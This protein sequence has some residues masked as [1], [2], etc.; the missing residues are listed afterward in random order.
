[1]ERMQALDAAQEKASGGLDPVSST[2]DGTPGFSSNAAKMVMKIFWCARYARMDLL[3]AVGHLSRH[4]TKWTLEC[5]K[6]LFRLMCYLKHSKKQRMIGWVGDRIEPLNLHLYS[7]ANYG[8]DGNK[9]TSGVHLM[10]E[11]PHTSFPI[12]G[13][14]VIQTSISHS[15]PEAEIVAGDL[16]LRKAGL[17]GLVMWELLKEG[18]SGGLAPGSE[19]CRDS[20]SNTSEQ[21]ATAAASGS[22]IRIRRELSETSKQVKHGANFDDSDEIPMLIFHDDNTA[23]VQICRS[24]RSHTMRHLGKV[25]GISVAMLRQEVHKPYMRLGAIPT[26]IMVADIHTKFYPSRLVATWNDVRRLVNIFDP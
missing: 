11:G 2:S 6:R 13:L 18:A 24:G 22:R 23:M 14:S 17:P 12:A 9:S 19:V 5:D 21:M 20:G 1:M 26:K 3:R 15:T 16:S 4:L 8:G 10:V 7:D 25:H